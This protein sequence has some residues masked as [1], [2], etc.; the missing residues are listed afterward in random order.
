[1]CP[2]VFIVSDA[3]PDFDKKKNQTS[4]LQIL[5]PF[6]YVCVCVSKRHQEMN[7]EVKTNMIHF[8]CHYNLACGPTELL[9][10]KLI[11]LRCCRVI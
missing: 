3:Q 1:M 7:G 10:P 4:I 9:G 8:W 2:I 5:I 6:S 11:S